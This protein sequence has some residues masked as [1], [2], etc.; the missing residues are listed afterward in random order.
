MGNFLRSL[1]PSALAG[2]AAGAFMYIVAR[3][4]EN[5]GVLAIN[6]LIAAVLGFTCAA[7]IYLFE[8]TTKH[9]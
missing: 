5:V 9:K 2:F 6:P 3:V 4:V 8:A 1:L 7:G